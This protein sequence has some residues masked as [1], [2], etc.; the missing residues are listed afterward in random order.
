MFMVVN[1]ERPGRPKAVDFTPEIPFDNLWIIV[2][3][4]WAQQSDQRPNGS[5]ILLGILKLQEGTA[6][7]PVTN[8]ACEDCDKAFNSGSP[9]NDHFEFYHMNIRMCSMKTVLDSS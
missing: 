7:K 6:T 5:D 2:A 9:L 1:G 3:S 4:C 8:D